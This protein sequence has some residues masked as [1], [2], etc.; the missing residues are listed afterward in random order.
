MTGG[1]SNGNDKNVSKASDVTNGFGH[2]LE[3]ASSVSVEETVVIRVA[4]PISVAKNVISSQQHVNSSQ[5][6]VT[7]SQNNVTSSQQNVTSSQRNFK[8]PPPSIFTNSP[9]VISGSNQNGPSYE[10]GPSNQN[11]QSYQRN[12]MS[13]PQ[14]GTKSSQYDKKISEHN[15]T[16]CQ[17]RLTNSCE[18]GCSTEKNNSINN[19]QQSFSEPAKIQLQNASKVTNECNFKNHNKT[20]ESFKS[21]NSNRA[22]SVERKFSQMS[23][24]SQM[25]KT[26]QMSQKSET[27]QMSQKSETSIKVETSNKVEMSHKS[28][29]TSNKVET[30]HKCETSQVSSVS[31]ASRILQSSEASQSKPKNFVPAENGEY[32]NGNNISDVKVS[33]MMDAK[34]VV[35]SDVNHSASFGKQNGL[36]EPAV[37]RKEEVK[38]NDTRSLSAASDFRP[39]SSISITSDVFVVDDEEVVYHDPECPVDDVIEVSPGSLFV[40]LNLFAGGGGQLTC[41][42][43]EKLWFESHFNF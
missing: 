2:D 10:N 36:K 9:K 15:M 4:P 19:C 33:T 41:S 6:N 1:G 43:T 18:V 29:T 23:Q 20:A 7:S 38:N 35:K 8:S 40:S 21:F 26:S 28:E 3:S 32:K 14:L 37:D 39:Y 24:W 42:I 31:Q 25:S 22:E 17:Q 12:T 16:S 27:S 30:S 34:N 5:Q 13:P 11:G